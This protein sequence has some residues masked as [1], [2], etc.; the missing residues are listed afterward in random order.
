MTTFYWFYTEYVSIVENLQVFQV[1]YF[2][3]RN[4]PHLNTGKRYQKCNENFVSNLL[5]CV[6]LLLLA[7]FLG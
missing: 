3:T 4:L 2:Q 6:K 1:I 7:C 5:F